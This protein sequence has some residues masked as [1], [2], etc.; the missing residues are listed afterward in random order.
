MIWIMVL[1]F[2]TEMEVQSIHLS[3]PVEFGSRAECIAELGDRR[4]YC[5]GKK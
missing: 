3:E 4:G 2:N 1:L 5:R